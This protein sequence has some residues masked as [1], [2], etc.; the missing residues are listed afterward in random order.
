MSGTNEQ[1][2]KSGPLIGYTFGG[3]GSII[4][5]LSFVQTQV[6]SIDSFNGLRREVSEIKEELPRVKNEQILLKK[7]LIAQLEKTE[8]K[9][10]EKFNEAMIR[11]EDSLKESI[12]L[13]FKDFSNRSTQIDDRIISR[14]QEDSAKDERRFLEIERR[15][16]DL[17]RLKEK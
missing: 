6:P 10:E 7:E 11:L 8:E 1:I 14:I 16:N 2:K 17:D 5:L 9:L 15:L 13:G 4:G 12:Q 3:I